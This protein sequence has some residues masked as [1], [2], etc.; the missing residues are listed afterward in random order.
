[1]RYSYPG[2]EKRTGKGLT[3]VTFKNWIKTRLFFSF[4][5]FSPLAL[6]RLPFLFLLLS[7]LSVFPLPDKLVANIQ[8]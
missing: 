5:Y 4:L 2:P 1:M 3:E 7:F 6:V 8:H